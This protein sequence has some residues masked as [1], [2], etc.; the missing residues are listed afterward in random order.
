MGI[1]RG[2]HFNG[3][4]KDFEAIFGN[5]VFKEERKASANALRKE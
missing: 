1:I 3:V 4:V 2:Y 5:K